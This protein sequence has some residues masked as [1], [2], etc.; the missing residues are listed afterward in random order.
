[1]FQ[2]CDNQCQELSMF[3]R[4][5]DHNIPSFPF[6]FISLLHSNCLISL[7][8]NREMPGGTIWEEGEFGELQLPLIEDG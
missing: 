6:T 1:M 3:G 8:T 7:A 5:H 2:H 4:S